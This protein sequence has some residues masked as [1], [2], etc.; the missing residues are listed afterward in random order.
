MPVMYEVTI[1]HTDLSY[2][3]PKYITAIYNEIYNKS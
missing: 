1:D 2:F 3:G